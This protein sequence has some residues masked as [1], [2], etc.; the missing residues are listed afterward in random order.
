MAPSITDVPSDHAR[1]T[2]VLTFGGTGRHR[3]THA[4]EDRCA[5][6]GDFVGHGRHRR[7]AGTPLMP[8]AALLGS[9]DDQRAVR[10]GRN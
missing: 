9:G 1:T 6:A 7:P 3:G 5:P 10:P 8:P 2:R 4:D